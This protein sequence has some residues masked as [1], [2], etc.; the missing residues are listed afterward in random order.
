MMSLHEH[1]NQVFGDLA[2]GKKHLEDF[3]PKNLCQVFQF[4]QRCH[5]EH[6]VSVKTTL[7]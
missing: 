3:M 2:L 7:A 1:V 6:A 5:T 4:E